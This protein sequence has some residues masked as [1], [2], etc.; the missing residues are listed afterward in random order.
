[1][2]KFRFF[3]D[4]LRRE[5]ELK[6]LIF[7]IL[8][9]AI[10]W[11][12]MKMNDRYAVERYWIVKFSDHGKILPDSLFSDTIRVKG[13]TTGWNLLNT[14][15]GQVIVMPARAMKDSVLYR[16]YLNRYLKKMKGLKFEIK[17]HK[18]PPV[19]KIPV[20]LLV[21]VPENQGLKLKKKKIRPDSLWVWGNTPVLDTLKGIHAETVLNGERQGKKKITLK[22]PPGTESAHENVILEY[23]LAPYVTGQKKIRPVVPD[24]L[25]GKLILFPPE[26]TVY[27]SQW[28]E[29]GGQKNGWKIGLEMDLKKGLIRPVVLQ[30]PASVFRVE[31][32]PRQ[33]D[34]LIKDDEK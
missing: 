33:L 24:S 19:K 13:E 7:F 29:S 17:R 9:S 11:F 31:L 2:K 26:V 1:M 23:E 6:T 34:Y 5:N 15:E 3:L 14:P 16:E 28:V 18:Y 22:R 30:K 20:Q 10:L 32:Y 25:R 21:R 8:L 4:F 12:F 27:Y